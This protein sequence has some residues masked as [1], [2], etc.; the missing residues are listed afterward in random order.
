MTKTLEFKYKKSTKKEFGFSLI[1]FD[2]KEI[3]Y[4]MKLYSKYISINKTWFVHI[5]T[6]DYL[7]IDKFESREKTIDNIKTLVK[8]SSKDKFIDDKKINRKG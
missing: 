8:L 7:L 4:L 2:K 5:N 3:G 6:D 1:L